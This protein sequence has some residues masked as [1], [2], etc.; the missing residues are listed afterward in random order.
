SPE[1]GSAAIIIPWYLYQWYGDHSV[2]ER[3]YP[4]MTRYLAYLGT[5]ADGHLLSHGLGDW[6]DLGPAAP[7]VSQLTPIGLTASAIYYYDAALMARIA[8]QLALK[9]DSARYQLLADRI[10][11]AFNAK[12]FDKTH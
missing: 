5:K 4:M 11:S 12:Y 1:W 2:L 6:F 8:G 7:G 3:A 10:R 9:E